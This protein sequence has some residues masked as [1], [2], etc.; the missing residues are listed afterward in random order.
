MN[1]NADD[2]IFEFQKCL[3]INGINNVANR[4][5]L[6]DRAILI[7][8]CRI[9][10]SDRRE[11]RELMREFA[12]DIP[13]ILG[14]IFD[15]LSKAMK[16]YPTVKLDK[17]PRMAD[18]ARWGYA[19]GEA[20]G[21]LGNEFLEQYRENQ[22]SRNIEVIHS[23]VVATLIV[24]LMKN[25]Y[26]W[27]GLI[28]ELHR[29][30]EENFLQCGISTK[31]KEFPAKPNALSRKIK[32]I[33]SNLKEVGISFTIKSKMAGSE[34]ILIN[35]KIPPLPPYQ[36]FLAENRETENDISEETVEF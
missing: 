32:E 12:N 19:I 16:I 8:L 23:N 1:T 6:L 34:I 14:G 4:S 24:E 5:D 18:F 7:E 3:A 35:E 27:K 17:L 15:T 28:S 29:V 9:D 22:N 33:E 11:L 26:E 30:L 31:C 13:Y 20:L 10:E 25:R 2:Y 36:Q 21:G